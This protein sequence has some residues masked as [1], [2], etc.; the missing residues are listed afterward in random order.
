MENIIALAKDWFKIHSPHLLYVIITLIIGWLL[1]NFLAKAFS[2]IFEKNKMDRALHK[3]LTVMIKVG[4]RVLL[5]ISVAQMLG[6]ATTSFIAILGAAGLA[7]GLSLQGSLAN[8]AGGILILTIRPFK[9]DHFIE[10]Q[11]VMGVVDDIGIIYTTIIT[12]NKQRVV[13]PNGPLANGNIINYSTEK[14][15]RLDLIFKIRYEEDLKKVKNILKGLIEAEKRILTDPAPLI[16]VNALNESNVELIIKAYPAAP[17]YWPVR[18]DFLEA[19][20]L[21][22]GENGIKYPNNQREVHLEKS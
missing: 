20:K 18:Y 1:I 19:V 6:I 10:A 14:T 11:G 17:D 16:A 4:L 13:I 21:A 9:I 22:F 2:K 15:R 7:I 8:F 5:L 12:V 3:F